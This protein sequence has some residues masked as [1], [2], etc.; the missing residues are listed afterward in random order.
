MALP[1]NIE[2]LITGSI[3]EDE[4]KE[5]KRGWNPQPVMHTMCA[6]GNDINNLGGGYIIIGIE[7]DKDGQPVLPPE[8]LNVNQFDSIQKDL[9]QLSKKILPNYYALTHFTEYQGEH[10]LVLWCPGGDNRPYDAPVSLGD[11]STGRRQWIRRYSSTV[12]AD[13]EEKQQLHE[14]AANVPYDDRVNHQASLDDID[15]SLVKSFLSEVD[16][17]LYEEVDSIAF[18]DLCQRMKIAKGAEENLQPVNVG[19]LMFNEHPEQFFPGAQIDVVVYRDDVGDEFSEKSFTGPIHHQLRDALHY[20]ETNVIAEQ[21]RKVPNQ[22]EVERFYNYPY[23]A[24]EE[25]IANAVYHRSYDHH[26]P[27]EVNIRQDQIEVLSFPGP[28]P[29]VDNK[30]LQERRIVARTYRNRRIGEFL[31]ELR[32]T[33]GR[34]TGFPKIYAA[35]ENNGSPEPHFETDDKASYFL[36]H[37]PI[38]EEARVGVQAGGQARD[39]AGDQALPDSLNPTETGILQTLD[40]GP[41]SLNELLREMGLTKRTG[42]FRR[43]VNNLMDY[44]LIEYLYPDAPRHPEQKYTITEIGKKYLEKL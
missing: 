31:K 1:I 7:E 27:I 24:I 34:A 15:K 6:F 12:Q 16:S 19:L 20:I 43:M 26:D 36:A 17:Q 8:G 44:G 22:A 14:L 32:L 40:S 2:E 5:F 29:P 38:H 41:S 37:I 35:M 9:I 18:K 30:K 10:I 33:E 11:K 13:R 21:V 4:R 25:V 3:V 39:Q 28:L 23:A 42:H